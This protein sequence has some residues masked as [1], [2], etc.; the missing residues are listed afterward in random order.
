MANSTH[1]VATDT[2]RADPVSYVNIV[3]SIISLAVFVGIF[4]WGMQT[5]LR[6]SSGVPVVRALD[7]PVRIAPEVPGGVLASHQGLTVNE[8]SSS[9]IH[10]ALDDRLQL[11]PRPINLMAE[12]QPMVV[13]LVEFAE[14]SFRELVSL[15]AVGATDETPSINEARG[16]LAE[17]FTTSTLLTPNVSDTI[18][19]DS[20]NSPAS[21]GFGL[22]VSLRPRVRSTAMV[23]QPSLAQVVAAQQVILRGA[24]MAQ[25]GAFGSKKMAM[26]AW[27]RLSQR[28]GNYLVG[29]HHVILEATVGGTIIYRLRVHGFSSLAESRRICTAL[30]SQNAECY[31]VLMN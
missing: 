1:E 7:G 9:Q 21:I 30:N 18:M 4:G 8:V 28:H 26:Q 31:S 25:L 3:G 17:V 29:K 16:V 15:E 19:T 12:D 23:S 5:I 22:T 6:D 10:I 13:L 27:T 11:A 14:K 20:T 2:D 24:P